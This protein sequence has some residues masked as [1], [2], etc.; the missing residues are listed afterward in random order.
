MVQFGRGIGAGGAK[1][2]RW[3][4]RDRGHHRDVVFAGKRQAA[5]D[6]LVE[7]DAERPDIGPHIAA[8]ADEMLRRH[9][10]DGPDRRAGARQRRAA[11]QLGDAEVEE[12]HLAAPRQHDVRRLDVAMNDVGV[13]RCRHRARHL[14]R[15][16][17]RLVDR[18]RPAGDPLLQRL[19]FVVR[20]RQ[21]HAAIWRLVDLVD[22]ADIR[23]VERG[24][25]LR[26]GD[27]PVA[28]VAILRRLDRQE[29][30]RNGASQPDVLGAVDDAHAAGTEALDDP[31]V[32]N[33]LADH[34]EGRPVPGEAGRAARILQNFR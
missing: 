9:V 24:G 30:Q 29:L 12:L 27:E 3:C 28:G 17:E 19:P 16:V 15:D 21:E 14:H 33:G 22:R 31:I 20:H 18:H 1:R 2:R 11:G 7:H 5:G 26:L 25:R 32:R 34:Q 13:V 4:V 6:H 8:L 10:G 23:M